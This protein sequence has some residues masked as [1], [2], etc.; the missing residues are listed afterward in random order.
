[1]SP[2][3][4]V[5]TLT[6]PTSAGVVPVEAITDFEDT[7]SQPLVTDAQTCRI[8]TYDQVI[9]SHEVER[10]P[11]TGQVDPPEPDSR[12]YNLDTLVLFGQ[13]IAQGLRN[14]S[15]LGRGEGIIKRTRVMGGA[16]IRGSL[17]W[18]NL[19]FGETMALA[20]QGIL[21]A[22]NAPNW[23]SVGAM[24]LTSLGIEF[25]YSKPIA[26]FNESHHPHEG[27]TTDERLQRNLAAAG[28][29]FWLGGAWGVEAG[30]LNNVE[31]WGSIAAYMGFAALLGAAAEHN[32][33]AAKILGSG[34][35]FGGLLTLAGVRTFNAVVGHEGIIDRM[36]GRTSRALLWGYE[37]Y[38]RFRDRPKTPEEKAAA[39]VLDNAYMAELARS[40]PALPSK[41]TARLG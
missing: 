38:R 37:R 22:N 28:Q 30:R 21:Q 9:A 32:N 16:A 24:L 19:L 8:P 23:V 18:Q 20:P 31:K 35:F 26:D 7:S 33:L 3:D 36:A 13:R 10:K 11:Y 5:I 6:F 39:A 1:M 40:Q 34:L 25:A 41:S 29:A 12:P 2:K 4:E 15:E 14:W 27:E 17:K